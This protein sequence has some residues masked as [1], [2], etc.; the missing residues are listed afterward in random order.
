MRNQEAMDDV[1]ANR[2]SVLSELSALQASFIAMNDKLLQA[3]PYLPQ[4]LLVT[5]DDDRDE[6]GSE[7][8]LNF[9][10]TAVDASS[11]VDMID[12][13]MGNSLTRRASQD[14]SITESTMRASTLLSSTNSPVAAP[15]SCSAAYRRIAMLVINASGFHSTVS[16]LAPHETQSVVS[17]LVSA[18]EGAVRNERGLVDSFHGDHFMVSFNTV[19][20]VGVAVRNAALCALQVESAV[21][22]QTPF[23]RVSMGLAEGRTLVGNM[24]NASIMKLCAVGPVCGLAVLLERVAQ[25]NPHRLGSEGCGGCGCVMSETTA[26]EVES[27]VHSNVIGWVSWRSFRPESSRKEVTPVAVSVLRSSVTSEDEEWMYVVNQSNHSNSLRGVIRLLSQD[28]LQCFNVAVAQLTTESHSTPSQSSNSL[29]PSPGVKENT[30]HVGK[31]STFV[32]LKRDLLSRSDAVVSELRSRVKTQ[33]VS[34]KEDEGDLGGI[35]SAFPQRGHHVAAEGIDRETYSPVVGSSSFSVEAAAR[36]NSNFSN[37]DHVIT[38]RQSFKVLTPLLPPLLHQQA[39][40]FPNPTSTFGF[41]TYPS[42]TLEEEY[43]LQIVEAVERF[44]SYAQL[45]HALYL[46]P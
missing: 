45:I 22:Q 3:R 42:L 46:N 19:R 43:V 24:G 15:S 16:A 28:L 6:E 21:R 26:R 10:G 20:L 2:T 4:A 8:S 34:P 13:E 25:A 29:P 23:K 17:G 40:T 27:H 14:S 32:N 9:N 12:R 37:D 7:V 5:V 30:S 41:N 11:N 33:V 44:G 18:V 39:C 36:S 38:L 35:L 31:D 1:A